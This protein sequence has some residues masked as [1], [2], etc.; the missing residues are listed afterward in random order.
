MNKSSTG[1]D[2]DADWNTFVGTVGTLYLSGRVNNANQVI[3]GT[4]YTGLT[5][6]GGSGTPSPNLSNTGW[7]TLTP[8][9]AAVTLWQLTSTVY[10]YTAD[11][12]VGGTIYNSTGSG[13]SI[14]CVIGGPC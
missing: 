3:A 6:V 13:V 11:F 10:P 5:R 12:R 9:G 4:T 2:I 14:V 1:N 8:G 7:Y